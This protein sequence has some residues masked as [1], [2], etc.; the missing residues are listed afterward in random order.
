MG[1]VNA[2]MNPAQLQNTLKNF[3]MESTKMDMK[4]EMSEFIVTLVSY[5]FYFVGLWLV[6]YRAVF[7][8]LSK[9]IGFGFGFG[10]TTP[11]GWLVYL[12]WFWFYDSQVKTALSCCWSN[13]FFIL[14][15]DPFVLIFGRFS[16]SEKNPFSAFFVIQIS[17]YLSPEFLQNKL[18]VKLSNRESIL[19]FFQNQIK[20]VNSYERC[21]I[22]FLAV[23]ET[24]DSI[25]DESGDEEEQE[26]I[27]NQVLDEIGIEVSGR[28]SVEWG[29]IVKCVK[30]HTDDVSLPRTC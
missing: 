19:G 26:A 21:V 25:L 23:N 28:V 15:H 29:S 18:P 30:F 12:L 3:E 8:W 27:V 10:F 5:Y 2:Q 9:G 16:H 1:S 14:I 6:C 17:N 24:L 4:E 20:L 11:F 13:R 7:T 22:H